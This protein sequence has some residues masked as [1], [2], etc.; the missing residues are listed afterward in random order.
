MVIFSMMV[1]LVTLGGVAAL[2]RRYVFIPLRLLADFTEKAIEG[3]EQDIPPC[4]TEIEKLAGN[5]RS[6]VSE[7]NSL[8][9]EA[10]KWKKEE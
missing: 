10:A 8:R 1:L 4:G 3:V 5:I 6:L 9:R 7:L 2:L